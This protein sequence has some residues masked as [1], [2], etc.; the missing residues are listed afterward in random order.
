MSR[1]TSQRLLQFIFTLLVFGSVSFS[2]GQDSLKPIQFEKIDLKRTATLNAEVLSAAIVNGKATDKEKFDAIL[3]WVVNNIEYD[4]RRYNSGKAF[5]SNRS[6]KRTLRRRKGICTDYAALMDSLCFYAGLQNVTITGYV[7]EVNFD[8]NDPVYFDNHAWNAVKLNGSWFLYDPTW[9]SGNVGWEYKPFAKWRIKMIQKLALRT[10]K[11]ELKFGS[12]IKNGKL[13]NLPKETVYGS[14]TVEF[15]R[16]F[17]RMFIRVLKW[18]PFKIKEKFNGVANSTWYLT[19]PEVFAVTHFPNNPIW[20][21]SEKTTDVADFVANMKYYNVPDYL[22]MDRTRHGTFC[23]PCDDYEA[24]TEI[25]REAKNSEASLR[26][27]PNN[28]FLPGNY[29]LMMG[30]HLFQ[31]VLKETD[32]LTKLHL[33]DSTEA[34][35]LKARAYYKRAQQDSRVEAVFH[36]K[37]NTAKKYVLLKENRKDLAELNKLLSLTVTKRNQIRTLAAKSRSLNRFENSFLN[38]FNNNFSDAGSAKK[39]K[40]EQIE[41]TRKK[42]ETNKTFCDSLTTEIQAIQERF[43]LNMGTLWLNLRE[44]EEKAVPLLDNYF[45][46]GQMRLF[47]LLDSYKFYIRELRKEIANDKELLANSINTDLWKMSDSVCKDYARLVKMI[48]KREAAFDKNKRNC[49]L[50]RRVGVFTEADVRNFCLE[51]SATVTET[52]CWNRENESLVRSLVLTFNY[53]SRV[54]RKSTQIIPWDSRMEQTR[55]QVIDR[56]V[57][58][59]QMRSK[60]A[61]YN[62]A[63][64]VSRIN[65]RLHDHRKKFERTK[66]I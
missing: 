64:L 5:S 7:K 43:K 58:R 65:T 3:S 2:F 42:I 17:P 41:K 30:G 45:T 4:S 38:R 13:C 24:S 55:Y 23:L 51:S 18:F 53:F 49:M 35:L 37:K 1:P 16:F 63:K 32:S 29:H 6:L 36:V 66:A 8:V 44:E 33:M 34:H 15:I 40:D 50:L 57:K 52:I 61:V 47:N 19:N 31:E 60:D 56:H 25:E 27:N 59:N 21:F 12:K 10:K 54:M 48:K 9:C 11:R 62:N 28:H 20:S 14:K 46:D 39:M 22:S 26:N